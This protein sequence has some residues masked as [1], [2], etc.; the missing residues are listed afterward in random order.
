MVFEIKVIFI[1]GEAVDLARTAA[2]PQMRPAQ[3]RNISG[4]AEVNHERPSFLHL[5]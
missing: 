1:L 3:Q 4:V 5:Y 2:G